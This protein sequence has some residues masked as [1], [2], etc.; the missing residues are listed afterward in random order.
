MIWT[1]LYVLYTMV[2]LARVA[3]LS[4]GWTCRLTFL[5]ALLLHQQGAYCVLLRVIVLSLSLLYSAASAVGVSSQKSGRFSFRG[6]RSP[7]HRH[8]FSH[9][10]PPTLRATRSFP[11]LSYTTRPHESAPGFTLGVTKPLSLTLD[12]RQFGVLLRHT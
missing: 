1:V 3:P 10:L 12:I 8:L 7:H 5:V 9:T 11:H 2:C 4:V 6:S